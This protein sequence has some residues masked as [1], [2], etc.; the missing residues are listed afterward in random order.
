[1]LQLLEA[2]ELRSRIVGANVC[3]YGK[4]FE[5]RRNLDQAG[6]LAEGLIEFTVL[7]QTMMEISFPAELP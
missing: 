1:M 2:G 4:E 3:E 6:L 7:R 5:L